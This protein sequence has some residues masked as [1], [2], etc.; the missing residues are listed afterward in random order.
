MADDVVGRRAEAEFL[1]NK[2]KE[3][4]DDS[5]APLLL[6]LKM[7]RPIRHIS[8]GI[9]VARIVSLS[10]LGDE[11]DEVVVFREGS[12]DIAGLLAGATAAVH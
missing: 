11:E 10:K 9:A 6:W 4:L 5:E 3:M 7:P 8:E 12:A 1:A 2:I